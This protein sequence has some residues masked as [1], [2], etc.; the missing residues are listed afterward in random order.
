MNSENRNYFI[1]NITELGGEEQEYFSHKIVEYMQE[2]DGG[3]YLSPREGDEGLLHKVFDLEE[4]VRV[5][6]SANATLGN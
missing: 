2:G 6:K 5:L 3:S 1:Q 4:E